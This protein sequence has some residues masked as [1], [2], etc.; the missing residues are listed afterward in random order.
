MYS[1]VSSWYHPS[2]QTMAERTSLDPVGGVIKADISTSRGPVYG[3]LPWLVF[4]LVFALSAIS[5]TQFFLDPRANGGDRVRLF[6]QT[7]FPAYTLAARLIHSGRGA[8]LYDLQTQFNEQNALMAE[9]YLRMT[10]DE[11]SVLRYPYPYTPVLAVLWSPFAPLSPLTAMALWDLLNLA[12]FAGGLWYLLKALSPGRNARLG[13]LLAGLTSFPLVNNLEQGQ[14]S[15]F[16]MLALALGIALLKQDRDLPA[17]LALGL[18]I[19]KIQW[20][21]FVVL[22]LLWK[23]RWKALGGLLA[24][25]AVL[26]AV[27]VLAAGTGWIPGYI[28]IFGMAQGFSRDLLLDPSYSHSFTGLLADLFGNTNLGLIGFANT[29][30]LL[31]LAGVLLYVWSEPWDATSSRWD[32]A[33]CLTV[34]AAMFT[35]PQLNT[36]DLCLLV[37]PAALALSYVTTSGYSANIR[38]VVLTFLWALYLAPEAMFLLGLSGPVRPTALVE[39]VLLGML[40]YLLFRP[41]SRPALAA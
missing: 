18:L 17:G 16:V 34:L 23:R 6:T 5:W 15:G 3:L 4:T 22:V 38:F 30:A 8:Q 28:H 29:G 33:M 1:T 24:S 25:S 20:L 26:L 9:G 37:L 19:I 31:L 36:H 39:L 2:V 11:A 13:L 14:S 12:A 35:Q 10:P 41:A 40:L 21:P 7:D 27:V 32:G